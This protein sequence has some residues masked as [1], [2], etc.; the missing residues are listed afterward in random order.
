MTYLDH[1]A[2]TPMVS[3]A[4]EALTGALPLLRNPSSLHA[5]GRRA[6]RLVEEAREELAAALGARPS[7]VI[8]TGGGTE[9]DNLAVK[10]IYWSRQAENPARRRTL[11]GHKVG[12]PYGV[13]AFVL[14]RDV[15]GPPVLHGGGQERDLRSGTLDVPAILAMA[16]AVRVAVSLRA[17]RSS[18]LASLRDSLVEAV[19]AAVPDAGLDGGPRVS[20]IGGG[21]SRLPGHAHPTFPRREGG[22][23]LM[24]FD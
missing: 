6:R 21:P 12:G 19:L 18:M 23:P 5:S 9:S 24:F 11:T 1:A 10:G 8:F 15:A 13:G 2:T 4:V 3:E 16:A 14:G 7:E 17:E 22:S 20:G